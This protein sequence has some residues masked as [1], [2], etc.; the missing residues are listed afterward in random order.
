VFAVFLVASSFLLSMRIDVATLAR[1]Q[2]RGKGRL[3]NRA[4]PISRLV[5]V[6]LGGLVIPIAAFVAANLVSLGDHTTPMSL[7]IEAG[8]PAPRPVPAA[9]V[10]NVVRRA[11]DPAVKV[12]GIVTLQAMGSSE[13]LEQLFGILA[14]DPA[15]LRDGGESQ[16]L[17][18]AIASFG[19]QAVPELM[20][21]LERVSPAQRRGAAG[22]AGDAFDRYFG[23]GFGGLADDIRTRTI[24]PAAQAAALA[25][26]ETAE[27]ALK[28]ALAD[29]E[30]S[31]PAGTAGP[32]LPAF[33]MQTLLQVNDRPGADLLAFARRTAADPG[34][35]DAVRGEALLL[36]GKLGGKDELEALYGFLDAP[37]PLLQA[38][39]MQAI[40]AV[41][42]RVATAPGH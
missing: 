38:R 17:A 42:L 27:R 28:L 1:R 33:V 34:W 23:S 37:S 6:V 30:P 7:A 9:L 39:A 18:K 8:L 5:K 32:G 3:L 36:V 31:A 2:R 13:A 20:R 10:G 29:L 35:S 4:D 24:D 21:R 22:P 14:E 11:T 12:Q 41:Q 16:A 26:L 25:R 40:A 19:A 15:A